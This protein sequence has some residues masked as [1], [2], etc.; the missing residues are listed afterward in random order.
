MEQKYQWLTKRYERSV[1]HLKLWGDNPRFENNDP[2]RIEDFVTNMLVLDT[3]KDNFLNLTQS[4]VEKGFIPADPIVVWKD[5]T[6]NSYF[7]AEGNRRIA[8]LKLLLEPQKAPKSI[9]NNITSYS[10][11]INKEIIQKIPVA[12]APSFEDTLWYINQR[13]TPSSN[14]KN[15]EEKII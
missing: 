15:G 1:K 9:R 8:A 10:E 13:H 5:T 12:I 14:Q 3:D 2:K 7:V 6:K 11:K 4:I